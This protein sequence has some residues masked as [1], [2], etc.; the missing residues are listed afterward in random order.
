MSQI[1]VLYTPLRV[2][3]QSAAVDTQAVL[4]RLRAM[5]G[6]E[7]AAGWT[8]ASS[9]PV[10]GSSG[11]WLV[12]LEHDLDAVCEAV[13]ERIAWTAD[14]EFKLWQDEA[15]SSRVTATIA[16]PVHLEDEPEPELELEPEPEPEPV[17]EFE[18]EFELQQELE[19][20]LL[21]LPLEIPSVLSGSEAGQRR[22]AAIFGVLMGIIVAGALGFFTPN[23]NVI[24][25]I[26]DP[27]TPS[28]AL[29]AVILCLLFWGLLLSLNRR[30]RLR[31]MDRLS[32]LKLLPALVD[33]LRSHGATGLHDALR[34]ESVQY[35]PL[36]RR[37]RL[38]LQQ[39]IIRPSLRNAQLAIE[40][41]IL[42]DQVETRRAYGLLHIFIWTAPV[43]GLIGALIG[44]SLAVG[45]VTHLFWVNAGDSSR[46]R[47]G[48]AGITGGF[49]IA[50][51][52]I[53]EGLISSFILLLM[54]SDLQSRE[55]RFYARIGRKIAE[56]FLP[57]LQRAAPEQEPQTSSLWAASIVET[58][59]KVMEVIDTAGQKLMANWD[60]RHKGYLADLQAAQDSVE[61]SSLAL[62]QAL[63]NGTAAIGFQLA[64][65]V[66]TQKA[67]L[68]KMLEDAKQ[69]LLAHGSDL[70]ESTQTVTSSLQ[71]ASGEICGHFGSMVDA[72]DEA[73]EKQRTL[74]QQAFA[75]SS[76]ALTEYSAETIRA[77]AAL[78]DL[79]KLTDQVLQSQATL[80]ETMEKLGDSKLAGVLADLDATLKDLKPAL[81]NLS[82]P[83]VLQAVPVKSNQP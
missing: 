73:A 38:I 20:L 25:P 74:T 76:Q 27:R 32:G 56:E 44:I 29:P 28:A 19:P 77:S 3:Y 45:G 42:S 6:S 57:E 21:P 50:F 18:P 23:G 59:Q 35:S 15:A 30:K 34:D 68:E 33:G 11:S 80:R 9:I 14:P 81:A 75:E 72:L 8:L 49:S 43:L 39:W 24:R 2:Q 67:A 71:Q 51:L 70:K 22:R 13:S 54:T 65:T 1:H 36:L 55:E 41:Q 37:I 5:V 62:V 69:G 7:L 12:T 4:E 48:L 82:Q 40:P 26:F 47:E 17:P 16:A 64:Q 66:A 53:L 31:A 60:E 78:N 52:V 63:E 83:F 79:A 58:T 10:S 46:I 61:R